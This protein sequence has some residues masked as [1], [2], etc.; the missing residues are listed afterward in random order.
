M[1]HMNEFFLNADDETI[2]KTRQQ[3]NGDSKNAVTEYKKNLFEK[4]LE[5]K[6]NVAMLKKWLDDW[7][8]RITSKR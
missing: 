3:Q 4:E 5:C 6:Q 2:Q 7:E 1:G 8:S